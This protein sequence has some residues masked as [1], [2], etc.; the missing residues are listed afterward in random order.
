[1][2][3]FYQDFEHFKQSI[4]AKNSESEIRKEYRSLLKKYHP[5][6]AE[7]YKQSDYQKCILKIV[8]EYEKYTASEIFAFEEQYNC[9]YPKLIKIARN[10][11]FKYKNNAMKN[12]WVINKEQCNHLKNAVR[13]Y[14]K[15]IKEC[16]KPELVKAAKNQLEWIYPLYN[17]QNKE[18]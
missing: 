10:E 15:V 14:E 16:K 11:Y 12:H 3:D 8:S 2:P 7:K 17:L 18:L 4:R 6:L 9:I 5:D 1:M 13:C